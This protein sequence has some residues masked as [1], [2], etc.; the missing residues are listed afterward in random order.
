[1]QVASH[2]GAQERLSWHPLGWWQRLS[3]LQHVLASRQRQ[4]RENPQVR[5]NFDP[6]EEPW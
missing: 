2:E 5:G 6:P 4:E 1:M 3:L